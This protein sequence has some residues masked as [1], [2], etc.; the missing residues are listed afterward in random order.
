MTMPAPYRM[1]W[2]LPLHALKAAL[3]AARYRGPGARISISG[4][5]IRLKANET[6]GANL[7]I[8]LFRADRL[9]GFLLAQVESTGVSADGTRVDERF[10]SIDD[11]RVRTS[12]RDAARKLL[13]RF[14]EMLLERD[15][16]RPLPI[17]AR[18]PA[19][20]TSKA[21]Q[22][23]TELLAAGFR[24]TMRRADKAA[25]MTELA[26]TLDVPPPAAEARPILSVLKDVEQWHDNGHEI[27]VGVVDDMDGWSRLEPYWNALARQTPGAKVFQA[28]EYLHEWWM[29]LGWSAQLHIIVALRDG[30]PA[31]IAPMQIDTSQ[32]LH[33]EQPCLK[34]LGEPPESDRPT[35]LVAPADAA[36]VD[37]IAD[38]IVKRS[39]A[40]ER[41]SLDEQLAD[42]N[43]FLSL[44]PRLRAAGFHVSC[45][46]GPADPIV[47]IQGNWDS[48]LASR[49]RGVRKNFKR[50]AKQLQESGAVL[51]E[52]SGE[53][54]AGAALE[55]YLQVE[56]SSWKG[57]LTIVGVSQSAAHLS[58][59]R[60]LARRW[61]MPL[62]MRFRFLTVDG[63]TIAATFGLCWQRTLYSCHVTHDDRYA[64]HSP[65]VVLTALE[66]EEAFRQQ[67]VAVIDF[68]SGILHNKGSWATTT[69]PCLNVH[70]DR[71]DWRGRHFQRHHYWFKPRVKHVLERLQLLERYRELREWFDNWRAR[72]D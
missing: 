9:V 7:S 41:M 26:L 13:G 70:V 62:G 52:A 48:Y 6:S 8:G 51:L 14:A 43:L 64:M 61:A 29:H 3:L 55:R 36:I 15:D 65:G 27:V 4:L 38:Y 60:E 39:R 69:L 53:S 31:A 32:W 25:G 20:R 2:L 11:L 67:D 1:E 72:R 40:W 30:V 22:F 56:A 24:I 57:R 28:Y 12:H 68:L 66:L 23:E 50:R 44:I 59:Y 54:S 37:R 10:I 18:L 34:Y 47:E 5:R 35:V 16:L 49:T 19:G 21:G 58:F 46:E 17:R 33:R 45:V 71:D 42:S 63:N